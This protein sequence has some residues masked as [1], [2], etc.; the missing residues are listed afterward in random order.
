M[1][2]MRLDVT[3]KSFGAIK[4]LSVEQGWPE[5]NPWIEPEQAALLFCRLRNTPDSQD[6]FPT[7]KWATIQR[8][9]GLLEEAV[10]MDMERKQEEKE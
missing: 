9:E 1:D 10:A 5:L 7:G 2:S 3:R 6:T 8:I 4:R